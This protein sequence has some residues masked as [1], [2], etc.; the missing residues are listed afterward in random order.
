M[1]DYTR[2]KAPVL[3][4]V[5]TLI[6]TVA[7]T[8]LGSVVNGFI[9]TMN[10]IEWMKTRNLNSIGIVLISLGAARFCFQWEIMAEKIAFAFYPNYISQV[11]AINIFTLFWVLLERLSFWF[12]CWLSVL[13]VVK[14]ANFSHPLFI[15]LK[16]IIPRI[17]PWLLLGSTVASLVTCFPL[18]WGFDMEY[19]TNSTSDLLPNDSILNNC[20]LAPD[21]CKELLNK[22]IKCVSE[23]VV[24][25][26]CGILQKKYAFIIPTV[27]V[28]YSLPFFIFCVAAFLLIKSLWNHTRQMKGNTMAFCNPNLEAH[29]IAIKVI[30]F[31]LLF[32]AFY[33]ICMLSDMLDLVTEENPWM[34]VVSFGVAA[35]PSLHSVILIWSNSKLRQSWERIF[36]RGKFPPG[37]H[38]SQNH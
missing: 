10:C 31:Y 6:I 20:T 27:C 29:F 19:R 1:T 5:I 13:Y 35:Y 9:V 12:A 4:Q 37:G 23:Y 25:A 2:G 34:L 22:S 36:H 16:L 3:V 32:S 11:P 28:G 14:I 38:T 26:E 18:Y 24:K 21:L 8:V 30:S 17:L 7:F 15:F 33:F